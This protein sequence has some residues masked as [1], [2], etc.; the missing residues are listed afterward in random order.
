MPKLAGEPKTP[1]DCR[2]LEPSPG[3]PDMSDWH[4][5]MIRAKNGHLYTGITQDVGRRFAEH[6]AGG[7]KAAKYLRGRGPL[8]LVFSQNIGNRSEALKAEA[9][10]KKMSKTEKEEILEGVR[11]SPNE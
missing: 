5:Y 11:V 4:L 1:P 10:V 9:A 3:F 6:V 8:K 7:R 2:P